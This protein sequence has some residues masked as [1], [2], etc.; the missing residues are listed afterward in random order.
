MP[1]LRLPTTT[2]LKL[3]L[4]LPHTKTVQPLDV[5]PGVV[6]VADGSASGER[7][8]AEPFT[9]PQP[10]RGYSERFGRLC[11]REYLPRFHHAASVAV[12]S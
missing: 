5:F 6:S 12:I 10:A 1:R 3:S 11:D 4:A 2:L 8:G 9:E 7:Q